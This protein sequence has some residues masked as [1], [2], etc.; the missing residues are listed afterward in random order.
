LDYRPALKNGYYWPF[1]RDA[2]ESDPAGP[3]I[4]VPIHTEMVPL[5]RMSTSKRMSFSNNV[6]MSGQSAGRKF[7]RALDFLRF[8]YPLKFDFCRMTLDELTS[9]VD[10]E[11]RKDREDPASYKPLVAIG[12]SKDLTDLETVDAFLSYLAAKGIGV[13]TFESLYSRLL[14][15]QQQTLS[16]QE[17]GN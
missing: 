12:H 6:G 8:R 2:N 5:W 11:S 3:W 9:M 13:S 17:I 10:R 16:L 4:E 1:S 7:N 15:Q 14:L